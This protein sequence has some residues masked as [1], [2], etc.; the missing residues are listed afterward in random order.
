MKKNRINQWL[1]LA[2]VTSFL[3]IM[4]T[5]MAYALPMNST[6][7]A[8][9]LI[10]RH[11]IGQYYY[12]AEIVGY[13]AVIGSWGQ[14]YRSAGEI[15]TEYSFIE[16]W[17]VV[18]SGQYVGSAVVAWCLDR[19]PNFSPIVPEP[20]TFILLGAGLAGL[21]FMRRLKHA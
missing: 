12:G 5:S 17:T 7:I 14:F 16:S 21:A 9:E 11:S 2:T 18:E 13:S 1:S 10:S 6:E 20:C 4:L 3:V 19:E 8:D 15:D